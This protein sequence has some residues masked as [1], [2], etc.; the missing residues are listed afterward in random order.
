M[1]E[2]E[3]YLSTTNIKNNIYKV[4]KNKDIEYFLST[5]NDIST[6]YAAVK[7]EEVIAP[8]VGTIKDA[9]KQ[10]PNCDF[11]PVTFENSPFVIGKNY[12]DKPGKEV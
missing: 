1:A 8:F 2:Q 5:N 9:V 10:F 4:I 6:M 3:Q 7:G 11:I 12:K